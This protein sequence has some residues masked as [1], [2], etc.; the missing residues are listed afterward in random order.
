MTQQPP[1]GWHQQIH[2]QQQNVQQN[3]DQSSNDN[4][5]WFTKSDGKGASSVMMNKSN[6]VNIF[7]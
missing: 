3:V 7:L 6:I 4:S 5:K 1:P 2:Q